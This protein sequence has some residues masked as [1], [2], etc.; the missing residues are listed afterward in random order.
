MKARQAQL[1]GGKSRLHAPTPVDPLLVVLIDELAGLSAYCQDAQLRRRMGQSLSLLLSQ[2]RGV[3]VL[4]VGALQDPRKDILPFRDLFPT[5][6]ALRLTEAAHVD[7]VLGDGA[8]NR[9]ALCD[10]IP[11]T[12][13]GVGYVALDGVREPMR[14]RAGYVTDEDIAAMAAEYPTPHRH[15]SRPTP[16][17][18]PG[19]EPAA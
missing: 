4:V 18:P 16:L 9:G 13:P 1:R 10:Q 5:R 15:A 7:M 6:I 17:D 12:M 11:E 19:E 14:V 3:G 2:G 8:R